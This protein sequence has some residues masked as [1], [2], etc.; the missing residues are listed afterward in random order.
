M[1]FAGKW[2]E[3]ENINHQT[4]LRNPVGEAGRRTEGMEG[5]YNPIGRTLASSPRV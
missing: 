2:M 1:N 3:L 5:D 4:E